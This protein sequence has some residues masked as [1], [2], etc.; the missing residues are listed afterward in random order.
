M[1]GFERQS[2]VCE[3]EDHAAALLEVMS[4][5]IIEEQE[6]AASEQTQTLFFGRHIA[7]WMAAF[8]NDLTTA[9]SASFYRAV[10]GFGGALLTIEAQLLD[11][12]L[13]KPGVNVANHSSMATDRQ[14]EPA[15]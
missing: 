2:G 14:Q 1:L 9:P 13:A 7:N 15:S 4:L 10:G 5:L 8:F 11:V 6:K 3:P 12:P